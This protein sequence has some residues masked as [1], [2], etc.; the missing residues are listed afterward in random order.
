MGFSWEL[1]PDFWDD[2]TSVANDTINFVVALVEKYIHSPAL[3]SHLMFVRANSPKSCPKRLNYQFF[4]THFPDTSLDYLI[5]I[6]S[7]P[8]YTQSLIFQFAHELGHCIMDCYPSKRAYEWISE[9]ICEALSYFALYAIDASKQWHL[10]SQREGRTTAYA[11]AMLNTAASATHDYLTLSTLE[12]DPYGPLD[13]QGNIRVRNTLIAYQLLK[14]IQSDPH[15]LQALTSMSDFSAASS[16]RE[17]I[18][19]WADQC[20][21]KTLPLSFLALIDRLQVSQAP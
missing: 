13:A 20:T 8:V 9:C 16:S 4:K 6:S 18:L 14:A 5:H 3:K 19:A 1:A 7:P 2:Y 15:C 21:N 12:N 11:N 17:F 10:I